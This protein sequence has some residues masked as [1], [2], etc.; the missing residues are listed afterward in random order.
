MKVQ[1]GMKLKWAMRVEELM[2]VGDWIESWTVNKNWRV[3]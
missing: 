3:K 2:K 1:Q